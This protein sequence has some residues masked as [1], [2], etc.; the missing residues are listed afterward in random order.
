MLRPGSELVKV[1]RVPAEYLPRRLRN[2]EQAAYEDLFHLAWNQETEFDDTIDDVL[3]G[4][5]FVVEH[6][7]TGY[8]SRRALPYRASTR[9]GTQ[10]RGRRLA[11]NR[12]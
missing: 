1:P 2:G 5:F 9:G 10:I 3:D 6:E 7:T 4:G 8:W 11:S 12:P